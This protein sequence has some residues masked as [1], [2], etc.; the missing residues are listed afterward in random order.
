[1]KLNSYLVKAAACAVFVILL[2]WLLLRTSPTQEAIP[3]KLPD[4]QTA[5][6][7]A[8]NGAGNDVPASYATASDT[9]ANAAPS[10]STNKSFGSVQN[11]NNVSPFA[12]TNTHCTP[13]VTTD[14]EQNTATAQDTDMLAVVPD[15]NE[16]AVLGA[17]GTG[18]VGG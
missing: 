6:P 10:F 14:A 18:V 9:S 17:L 7:I 5:A 15:F 16:V 13:S 1:M 12:S 4:L 2:V 3:A 8:N 11:C